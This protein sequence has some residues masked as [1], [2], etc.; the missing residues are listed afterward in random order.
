MNRAHL[1]HHAGVV[2]SG[3]NE[4]DSRSMNDALFSL[5]SDA[6]G[7]IKLHTSNIDSLVSS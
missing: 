6:I 2:C 7:Y 4:R 1:S 5:I 3:V